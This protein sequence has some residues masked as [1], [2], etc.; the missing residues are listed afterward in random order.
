MAG[1]LSFLNEFG[2]DGSPNHSDKASF[3]LGGFLLCQKFQAI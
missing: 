3:V 1:W 2:R